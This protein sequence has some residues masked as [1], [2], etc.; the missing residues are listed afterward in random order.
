MG[1][2]IVWFRRD[3]RLEDNPALVAAARGGGSV[4]PVYIWC[5]NE[6]AQFHP[7]RVSRWWL[8]MS[9]MHLDQSLR[10]LGVPLLILRTT[11]T[12]SALLNLIQS[13]GATQLFYNR[14]YDPISLVRD[15]KLKQQLIEKGYFVF[16]FNGDLLYESW[17]VYDE[18]GNAFTRFNAF[19]EKCL[20]MPFD[21]EAPLLPP[22]KLVPSTGVLSSCT[23]EELG[24]ETETEKTSNALLER[25][26]SPGWSH[27]DK[28]L[29][30]FLAGPLLEYAKQRK[31][32]DGR[33][34]SFL[35]PHIHFGELSVR[36][37]FHLVRR[38]QTIWLR[39]R[40]A[41]AEES[42]NLFLRSIGLREYSRYLCFNFPFTHERPLLGNLRFFPWR[43]DEGLFKAW[44]QG[45]TGYPFVDAGM[46]QLWATGWL[47]NTVR[48]IV[49]SFYVKFLQLPWT[50]GM[51]YFWDTLLDADIECD[52][53]GWQYVSGSLPDGHELDRIE[54][55]QAEGCKYDPD[56]EYV[57]QW[58]PE[59]TR[60]PTE[61]IHHPWNAPIAV[62]NAAGV[63]L[64]INYPRPIV[65]K[66]SA[67][68]R[69]QQALSVMW[70][71]DATARREEG[72]GDTLEI[73]GTGG[74]L[75]EKMV[76]PKVVVMNKSDPS[77]NPWSDQQV[78]CIST[79]SSVPEATCVKNN[80][81]SNL[82]ISPSESEKV[83]T[84]AT[85]ANFDS[86]KKCEEQNQLLRIRPV[87]VESDEHSTAVSSS[88]RKSTD[89]ESKPSAIPLWSQV[90]D[91]DLE[92][93]SEQAGLQSSV[94]LFGQK[95]TL[96]S[97]NCTIPM[98][99]NKI[100]DEAE[101][102]VKYGWTRPTKR[103]A[104]IDN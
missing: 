91:T 98:V 93:A 74:P 81:T 57:R 94:E 36:K 82:Q 2:S 13:T 85:E 67:Q 19:W 47:H 84:V 44:R 65:E 96:Q 24:L 61:W 25:A 52:I 18:N 92:T 3:L 12:L 20:N 97:F 70:E 76:V 51:K 11:D 56:G 22:R 86:L 49:S 33:N 16:N 78:P 37:V 87:S 38:K 55:P 29:D 102:S 72:L 21:P 14:L 30:R 5:P 17:Q 95:R 43:P 88:V 103:Q 71:R 32:V 23:I 48:V 46:R 89:L 101:S 80:F 40:K 77:V 63:E 39:E 100:E 62:L 68:E 6:E 58:L 10:A 90:A 41:L 69:L 50:W 60:M 59:L 104:R 99:A 31:K 64:G 79:A 42:V 9:L 1:C 73:Q 75:H 8:K 35:S 45:R 34:T 83:P 53:L 66:A 28:A 27:A 54:N 15:H 7:G 26:W 4:V